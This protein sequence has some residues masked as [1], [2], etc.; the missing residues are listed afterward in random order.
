VDEL[1]SLF[2][3]CGFLVFED[4]GYGNEFY[5]KGYNAYNSPLSTIP[6]E[7]LVSSVSKNTISP[8]T[9]IANGDWTHISVLIHLSSIA[10]ISVLVSCVLISLLFLLLLLL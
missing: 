10:L 5:S 4:K 3:K 7:K 6:L 8:A 1:D 2:L 9:P